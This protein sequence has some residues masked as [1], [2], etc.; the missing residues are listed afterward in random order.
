MRK[1]QLM[2]VKNQDIKI[3]VKRE[4]IRTGMLKKDVATLLGISSSAVTGIL[5]GTRQLKAQELQTLET[6][7]RQKRDAKAESGVELPELEVRAGAGGGGVPVDT[8]EADGNG[9]MVAVDAVRD[10]WTFPVN[11][12]RNVLRSSPQATTIIEVLGDSMEPT[13]RPGDRVF[14]DTNH[15]HPSPPGVFAVWDGFG[16]VVKRIELVPMS[17]PPQVRLI[18]DNKNHAIYTASL[19]DA[20]IIGR[21]IGRI[22][23]M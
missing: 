1:S 2:T 5:N 7:F 17:D 4:I 14:I 3:F 15:R 13:M 21:V 11:F 6:Y 9:G 8:W 22:T 19:A 23:V 10:H 12:V 20:H 16:I 18:S